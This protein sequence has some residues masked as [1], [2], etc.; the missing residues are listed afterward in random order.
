MKHDIDFV[1]TWLDSSDQAWQKDYQNYKY[2][3]NKGD[4]AP[5]RFRDWGLFRYWF[6]SIEQYAPW[7][8]KVYLVTNGT[9][10]EWINDKHEKLVLVN[11]ADYI[12]KEN[13]PTFNSHTIEL[14]LHKIKGLSEHFVYFNDD[15]YLN[16]PVTPNYYFKDGLPCD[17]NAETLSNVPTYTKAS[18][19]GIYSIIMANIGIINAHFN[20]WNVVKQSPRKWFGFHLDIHNLFLSLYLA[21]QNRFIGFNWR[22]NEQPFLKSVFEEIWKKEPEALINSCTRFREEMNLS[23]YVFRYW[24]FASNKFFPIKLNKQKLYPI[25]KEEFTQICEALT[26]QQIKSICLNDVPRCSHEDFE[27]L[28]PLLVKEF[29]KKYPKKSAFEK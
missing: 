18:R 10:P 7:V 29:E 17:N 24:Q 1:V 21:R 5:A 27:M 3:V 26:N 8:H 28:C 15:M 16:G 4:A 6:R 14:H 2:A 11:H 25:V 20:R 22:H 9:F 19:F 12:P 23:P 13:L